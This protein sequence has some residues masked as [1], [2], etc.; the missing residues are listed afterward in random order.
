M[1]CG[2]WWGLRMSNT[3]PPTSNPTPA[4]FHGGEDYIDV[5][6][7]LFADHGADYKMQAIIEKTHPD[8]AI[9]HTTHDGITCYILEP[10]TRGGFHYPL[11]LWFH[12]CTLAIRPEPSA[13]ADGFWSFTA[14]GDPCLRY[15]ALDTLKFARSVLMSLGCEID[16]DKLSRVDLCLDLPGVAPDIF[17]RAAR[18]GRYISQARIYR[19]IESSSHTVILGKDPLSLSIYNRLAVVKRKPNSPEL[20]HLMKHRRWGG[21]VPKH[22]TRV[23]FRLRRDALKR[24]GIDSPDDYFQ[25]RG[26]LVRHLCQKAFRFTDR[27]VDRNNTTRAKVLPLWLDIA[28][29]FA[30]WAGQPVGAPLK[31]L[32]KKPV[33]VSYLVKQ[34]HGLVKRI[35][36]ELG[37]T[38][39]P[40]RDFDSIMQIQTI[41]QSKGK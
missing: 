35:A 41:Q 23:E 19:E 39:I 21:T 7:T 1:T 14:S 5:F 22:A 11:V 6:G 9:C 31:P 2:D 36:R 24:F 38:P 8:G 13:S 16:E 4:P 37:L 28:N 30:S 20:L 15:G 26:D 25:R 32:P 10:K 34:A 17:V 29:G 33:N 18:E 3:P 40:F 27:R 12:G